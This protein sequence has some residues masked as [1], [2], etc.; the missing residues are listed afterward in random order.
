MREFAKRFL[1]DEAGQDLIEYAMLAGVISLAAIAGAQA[2]GT[3]LDTQYSNIG[4]DVA[5]GLP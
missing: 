1:A 5:N 3:A 2:L 4:T